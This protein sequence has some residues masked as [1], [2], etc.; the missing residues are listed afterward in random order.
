MAPFLNGQDSLPLEIGIG[1]EQNSDTVP[2]HR[3]LFRV[4]VPYYS[5]PFTYSQWPKNT[6]GPTY[7]PV[8]ERHGIQDSVFVTFT[9]L[10]D[11]TVAPQSV[12]L[13]AGHYREFILA[14]FD[15]LATARYV[16]ARI[17]SCPVATW[18]AQSFLF[19]VR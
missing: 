8:A 1:I 11:G 14:V 3:H 2:P 5:L 12:D 7:P 19:R 18:T 16:A 15:R 9:T 13:L 17:G 10:P 6:R 4:S